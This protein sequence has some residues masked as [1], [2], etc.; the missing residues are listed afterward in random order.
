MTLLLWKSREYNR[1]CRKQRNKESPHHTELLGLLAF[2]AG[3]ID[4]PEASIT[5]MDLGGA[6]RIKDW[7]GRGLLTAT[8]TSLKIWI[9]RTR[10]R[11]GREQVVLEYLSLLTQTQWHVLMLLHMFTHVISWSWM[12]VVWKG[13]RTLR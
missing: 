9:N 8:R 6:G 10:T 4:K 2:L 3:H 12:L 11:A 5:E 7:N 1:C 13:C